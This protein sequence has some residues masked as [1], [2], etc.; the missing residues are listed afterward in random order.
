MV[1]WFVGSLLLT[2]L[3]FYTWDWKVEV[4]SDHVSDP[5]F[6][7]F[8][9]LG[10]ASHAYSLGELLWVKGTVKLWLNET[11]M[12]MIRGVSSFLIAMVVTVLKSLGMS[13][14]GFEI[15][16]KVIDE[17]ALKRYKQKSW[18]LLLPPQCLCPLPHSL[19]STSTVSSD[20][21]SGYSKRWAISPRSHG[22]TDDPVGLPLYEA[23]FLR[24]DRGRMPTS[25]TVSSTLLVF[26]LLQLL[27]LHCQAPT[28]KMTSPTSRLF[29]T[30]RAPGRALFRLY[31][32]IF[33]AGIFSLFYYRLTHIP[34]DH[35][36]LWLL[37]S[38]AEFWFA[39]MWLFQQ[40]LRWNPTYHVT[41]PER[42][43]ENLPPVDVM[44]CTADPDREPPALVANTLL[45]LMAYDYDVSKLAFYLSDD[46]GSELTFHAA[47]QASIFASHW[48]PFCR[49]YNVEPR[50]PQAF[51]FSSENSVVDRGSSGIFQQDYNLVKEKF[52]EMQ[53]KICSTVETQKVP[54]E[55]RR[56]HKGFNEWKTKVN[57]VLLRGDGG[58][59]DAEGKPMPTLVYV[60]REKR[61]GH[62]HNFKAGALNALNRVSAVMSNAPF[63]LNVDCDM[64][65][66]NSRTLHHTMCFFLYPKESHRLAFVQFPQCF[67]GLT[68]NDLYANGLIRPFD[69]ELHGMN[70]YNGPLYCGTGAIHRRESLNGRKF[71]P[72]F[73]PKW[74]EKPVC[75][76]H[77]KWSELEAKAKALTTRTSEHGKPWGKEM[78]LMYGCPVEDLFTGLA[79][80]SR[81]WQSAY[82]TPKRKAFLGLAPRN[83]NDSLIQYK[84][85]STGLLEVFFSHLCPFTHGIGRLK[86]GQILCYSY[87]ILW[88]PW[89]LPIL[90]YALLPPLAMANGISLFPK[91]FAFLGIASHA[92][93]LGELLWVKGTVK[94][95]LNET[96]M[97]M[98]RGVSSFLIAMV[99]TVLKALGMSESGFEITS[100]VIDEEALKRYKQEVMELAVA[101]PMFVPPTALS[102][103]NLY[104]FLRSTVLMILKGGPSVLDHMALQMILSGFISLVSL[105]LYEA[106]FLR[107]DK[108]RMPTSITVYSTLLVVAL[109]YMY[110][111]SPCYKR[112]HLSLSLHCQVRTEKMRYS[113]TSRLFT[114]H[115]SP[116]R[117][118]FKLYFFT[119]CAGIF[120]HLYYRVTHIL[121]DHRLLWVLV[122]LAELWFAVMWLFQ[123]SCRWNPTHYVTHPERLPPNLPPVDVMLCTADPDKEPPALVANTLLSLMA[124]DY[125]V[126]KLACYLSDDGGSELTFHAAYQATIF[127]RHWLPFCRKYNVGPRAPQAFFSSDSSAVNAGSGTFLQDYNLEKFEEMQDRICS[128]M[129]TG[130]VPEETRRLHKGFHEWNT[131]LSCRDHQ[132]IVEVLLRGNGGDRDAEGK[133]MPT[134]VYVSREKR[135]AHPHNFKAGALN[136]LNRVSSVMSNAPFILNVDC[137]MYSNNSQTLH[138]TMCFFL[139]PVE[140]H[141]IAF[142]QF[143]QRFKG[144]TPNDLYANGHI[145]IL[146]AQF[147]D[148]SLSMAGNL[149]PIFNQNGMRKQ[150][151]LMYGCP[152]EDLLTGLALHKRGWQS[153]Y[154]IPEKKAFLGLAPQ[155]TNDALIQYKRW[156]TGLLEVFVSHLFPFTHGIER[157]KWGQIMS[158]NLFTL[159]ATWSLPIFCYA[160]LPPLAM[161]KGISLFPKASDPWFKVFAF[162]GIASHAYS[163]GELLSAKGTVKMWW[164]ETRMWMI[165][166]VSSFLIAVV[167]TILKSLGISESGFEITS[168]VID[169]D[170]LKR[171][172]QEV[173]EF[174]VA[175]PMF[176]PPTTLSLLNLYCL[177]R[178]TVLM[179]LQGEPSVLDHMALQLI[180]SGFISLISLPLYEASFLRRDKGR[181][182]TSITAYSTLLVF[183]LLY[184]L[185][186]L[187]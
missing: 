39:V 133:P 73:R 175:S 7:V 72:D 93:S 58:D 118:L 16:S 60:S 94:M 62:P 52:E 65:S 96:R 38:L 32:F 4:G 74:D 162:L 149:R 12:W 98:I 109:L 10:I 91:V 25:I 158:Y 159:W 166:G 117:A 100:K 13:E 61:P 172:K 178:S 129:E 161:A 43:P 45:S 180:L 167:V 157:L 148:V 168:K 31:F 184:L 103:L 47:Y 59:R 79:L 27:V 114:T 87:F 29:T 113:T 187:I 179:I 151:G 84:R 70:N 108:G 49:K 176:V 14:S 64:Y 138:H 21:R 1:H 137:D 132:S 30:H 111:P 145:K 130:K 141:R 53:E 77:E 120:S 99:V 42:L 183:A 126:S 152:V 185:S 88:A 22:L 55:T 95:W 69:I 116:G 75:G 154:F 20:P 85:W 156:S 80:H 18:S 143:P 36:L 46:G 83:T 104:C 169:D 78:G 71:T 110:T 11:R 76:E 125:D 68:P 107:R 41:H 105:P 63:I 134:L 37:V 112:H 2:P 50:A 15:T 181:M 24:R 97:W 67:V 34:A 33:A 26:A 102:L 81:G 170:A 5:W 57:P 127:A 6:N 122:S 106:L 174:A 123:Q 128:T 40:S 150:M 164:N 136:A 139:D 3:P 165:R 19:Y 119:F 89:S 101:S 56:R 82:L 146:D 142:V 90:C 23:L 54:E 124:Y 8:A 182:P 147:T 66:N 121:A 186:P 48:L 131:K 17:E 9:F 86:W 140:S 173:M 44:V 160:L 51:F 35:R 163:L 115:K 155:N 28:E 92:Y 144:L 135:P 177:L 153:I 171:Y